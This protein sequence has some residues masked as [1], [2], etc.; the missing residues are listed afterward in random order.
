MFMVSQLNMR[1]KFGKGRQRE[2]I[3]KV[4]I[5]MACPSLI[6]I[7]N[8]GVGVSYSSLKNYYSERR[9]LSKDLFL[10]LCK[11]ARID[12][13]SVEFEYVGDNWGQVKGGKKR[14]G[15]AQN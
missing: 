8:R 11:I 2:F 6:E 12:I 5:S 3:E 15:P 7:I 10:E 13:K 9:C 14:Y 1:V 4:M